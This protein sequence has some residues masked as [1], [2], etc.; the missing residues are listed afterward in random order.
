MV[1]D[2]LNSPTRDWLA[3]RHQ[4]LSTAFDWLAA[5]PPDVPDGITELQ[6]KD[7]YVNVH[8]YETKPVEACRWESH[9]FTVDLQY[10]IAGGELIEWM[11]VGKL[12]SLGDYDEVKEVEHWRGGDQPLTRLTL[13]P[14]AFA[15]FLPNEPHRPQLNDGVNERIRKLVFKIRAPLLGL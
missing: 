2:F 3:K 1:F 14:G 7:F 9:R 5:M 6:G 12:D 13:A 15:L 8:G 4:V 11:P 10:C